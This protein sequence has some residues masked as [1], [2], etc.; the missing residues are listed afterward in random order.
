[1]NGLK[2]MIRVIGYKQGWWVV[3]GPAPFHIPLAGPFTTY[4][5]AAEAARRYR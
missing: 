5:A 1:M 2:G 4:Q 3:Q